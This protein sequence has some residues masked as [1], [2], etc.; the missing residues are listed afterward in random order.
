V[1]R[2]VADGAEPVRLGGIGNKLRD[3][4]EAQT[5]IETRAT[6]LGHLQRGG[7]PT[8][9][10]RILATRLGHA[11]CK[12]AVQGETGFMVGLRGTEIVP[13]PLD[14]I[15]GKQ[16]LIEPTNH[17]LQAARAVGTCFGDA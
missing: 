16:R 10:D 7:S 13:V 1:L 12:L 15:A 3:D 14:Q 17:L 6:I 11:A 2:R 5:G 8:P 9:F 4:I